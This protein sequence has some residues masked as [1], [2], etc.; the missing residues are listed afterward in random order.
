MLALHNKSLGKAITQIQNVLLVPFVNTLLQPCYSTITR[1]IKLFGSVAINYSTNIKLKAG[2]NRHWESDEQYDSRIIETKEEGK[3]IFNGKKKVGTFGLIDPHTKL[4]SLSTFD[5]SLKEIARS[6]ILRAKYKWQVNPRCIWTDGWSGYQEIFK[7]LNIHHGIVIHRREWKS[8]KGHH[9]NNIE[10]E[11][12]E[13]RDWIKHC[14]GF[15]TFEGRSF[16]DQFYEMTRNFFVQ[17]RALQG[18]T[19][20]EKAGVNKNITW[21]SLML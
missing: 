19:P 16:Y 3:Y 6:A 20:A 4:I 5:S 11:W 18:L 2:S 7:E 21:L 13:K 9:D 17:R 8:K 12:V 15:A 10:R 14:R 1:W